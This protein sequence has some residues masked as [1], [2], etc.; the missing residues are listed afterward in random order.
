MEKQKVLV[1]DD[2]W[3][4]RQILGKI[5]GE[6]YE[7]FYACNGKECIQFLEE[8]GESVSAV[9]LDIAMPEMDGYEVLRR[10]GEHVIYATIPVIVSSQMDGEEAEIK[11]LSL[12]AQDYISKPYKADIIRHRLANTIKLRETALLINAVEKDE[13]T[14]LYNKQF[15]LKKVVETLRDNPEK[16]YDLI[17]LD[18]EKFKLINDTF[19]IGTGDKLLCFIGDLLRETSR[20]GNIC[21]HFGA[22][23]FYILVQHKMEYDDEM[24]QQWVDKFNEFPTNVQIKV[25]FG[26]YKITS[27]TLPVNTMCD[28]AKLATEGIKGK[29]N[30]LFAY[31]DD[32]IRQRLLSERFITD[33]MQ[34]ALESGQFQVFY[35]PKYELAGESIVGA[36]A[37]VRWMHSEKGV[38]SPGEFIPLFERNGFIT[39]LD[40][41]V[42]ET[43]CRCIRT[44]MDQGSPLVPISVNVS[45]AD[46]FSQGFVENLR[47]L[48]GKY[49]I[50]IQSLHLEITE[51]A[52][53]E[54]P[55]QIIK[56]VEQLRQLG[57]VIE[58]DDFGSGYSSLNML[59]EIPIDVLKLDMRF[60]KKEANNSSG[61]GIL[62]FIISLAKWLNLPVIAEGVETKEQT[63]ILRMMDC[64][65]VQGY[66]FAKPMPE[67]DFEKLLGKTAISAMKNVVVN[68]PVQQETG[69]AERMEILEEQ[70]NLKIS[71]DEERILKELDA[72]RSCFDIVRLVDP[73]HTRVCM[74]AEEGVCDVQGCFTTWGKSERCNNCISLRALRGKTRYNKLEYTHDQL[75]FVISQYVELNSRGA[76]V[77]M[78]SKLD[79]TYVDNIFDKE[80]LFMKLDD[81]NRQLESDELTGVYN[82]RHIDSHLNNY[83]VHARKSGDDMGIAMID[84]DGLKAINDTYGHLTGDAVI[85]KTARILKTNFAMSRGDFVARYGGDEFLVV[86]RSIEGAVFRKRVAEVVE[87]IHRN[88]VEGRDIRLGISAGCVS[89]S[90]Y[91]GFNADEMIEKADERM[92]RA[93]QSGK[94]RIE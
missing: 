43:A 61:R 45:R 20:E 19:G 91:P 87:I 52:Y 41:Y 49:K 94:N 67:D 33:S 42:W 66:Y 53:T 74:N 28:R 58:M 89:L 62:R 50:P 36:E 24:F 26:I 13:L 4:N 84:I 18:I 83:I 68:H 21:S 38:M 75:F 10:M 17:C 11:A 16:P 14:G 55:E 70:V 15:F 39:Q 57:F 46:I 48:V 7:V 63:E 81:L 65:Y 37:L 1:V 8:H 72:L 22:D 93:K 23:I 47:E 64:N 29:Y 9:V 40:Y 6:I 56:V 27:R 54:D 35:Q 85:K 31:Y 92:Y 32:R 3:I 44:R 79:D 80:L 82:R 30:K 25:R 90:E 60:I 73:E 77:E 86:C 34:H 88:S 76:V 2:Q 12:G 69:I 5:L 71:N 78:V 59:A 51:T